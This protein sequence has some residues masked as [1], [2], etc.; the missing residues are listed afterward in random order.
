MEP[1]SMVVGGRAQ[2]YTAPVGT[3]FPAVTAAPGAG[4]TLLGTNGNKSVHEDGITINWEG[5]ITQVRPAGSTGPIKAFRTSEGFSLSLTLLDMTLEQLSRA[6]GGNQTVTD[7]GASRSMGIYRGFHIQGYAVLVRWPS[8]YDETAD[9]QFQIPHAYFDANG[10]TTLSKN[11]VSGLPLT[12]VSLVDADAAA[13][14]EFGLV[15]AE[16]PNLGT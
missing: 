12:I 4:W 7:A 3:A 9:A 1:S 16:D 6:L 5:D 2:V 14:D 10:E 13:G 15:I 11:D 8:P